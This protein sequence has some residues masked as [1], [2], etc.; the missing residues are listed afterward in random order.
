[1]PPAKTHFE[2][3]FHSS[4]RVEGYTH[5]FYKYPARFSPSFVRFIL[6]T[7]TKPG[8]YVI[9]PFMGGGTTIVEAIAS[10][11]HAIGS[12]VN[13]LARFV[14]AAKTTP[15]SPQDIVDVRSWI[16]GVCDAV[17]KP[18]ICDFPAEIPIRNMPIETYPFF[19]IAVRWIKKLRFAR[20]RRFARCALIRVG[21]WALDAKS[22]IPSIAALCNE[23]KKRVED[24]L[25][26]L[27][28]F[29]LAARSAGVYK[30]KIT[31]TRQL[32]PYS[33]SD[34]PLIRR[35]QRHDIHPNL[36]LTSPPYPGVHVLYHRWQV[37]GRRET[38]APYWIANIKDG[39]GASHYTM[40]SRSALGMRDYFKSLLAAF[41]NLKK[42]VAP[43]GRVVQLVSFRD[44]LVQLPHYLDVMTSAGFEETGEGQIRSRLI[45]SVPHRKWYTQRM[46]YNDA[47]REMLLIHRPAS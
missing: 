8:D 21:Q 2:E 30:N 5:D 9:D 14:T 3:A 32:L 37:L 4:V 7:F 42:I 43:N 34:A 45:R 19:A 36:V 28:D 11:R 18:L 20:C 41:T 35:L 17:E 44:T 25:G 46:P 16:N 47:S 10:G 26:G 38:P 6:Q 27:N 24:M 13:E 29:V 15:L 23:L 39:H 31:A 33:A 22:S 12:D 1:M 40:G